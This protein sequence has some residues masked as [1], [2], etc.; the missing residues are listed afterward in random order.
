MKTM[1]FLTLSKRNIFH[2]FMKCNDKSDPTYIPNYA[3]LVI[4]EFN[5]LLFNV[6]DFNTKK[7]LL[8]CQYEDI[9]SIDLSICSRLMGVKFI[10]TKMYDIEYVVHTKDFQ[11]HFE[12]KNPTIWIDILHVLNNH[13]VKINDPLLLEESILNCKEINNFY[14]FCEKNIDNWK[15]HFHIL[16]PKVGDLIEK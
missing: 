1:D 14:D 4:V 13:H 7:V 11:L 3:P 15:E 10:A 5:D 8:S 12:S 9:V 6:K 2:S 16:D